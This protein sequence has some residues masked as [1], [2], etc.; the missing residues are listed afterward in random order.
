MRRTAFAAERLGRIPGCRVRYEGPRFK[1]MVLETPLDG[2]E[3][4]SALARRGFLAGPSLG[5][6]FPELGSCVLLAITE[7]RTEA[8]IEGLAEAIEKE[9]A[10]R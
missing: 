6:W 1:E 10:D 2:D 4:V 3:L 8:D 9:V 5:R 7:R